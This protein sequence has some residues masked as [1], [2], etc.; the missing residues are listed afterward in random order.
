MAITTNSALIS[1]IR[2]K[3]G[4]LVFSRNASGPFVREYVS[5]VQPN[6]AGQQLYTSITADLT[7]YWRELPPRSKIRWKDFARDYPYYNAL[8]QQRF[9]TG[10]QLFCRQNHWIYRRT[11]T[12]IYDP[13][14]PRDFVPFSASVDWPSP[15]T[16]RM[17]LQNP[18]QLTNMFF[19][20][21]ATTQ[22]FAS[23]TKFFRPDYRYFAAVANTATGPFSIYT[24]YRN[25]FPVIITEDMRIG[26]WVRIFDQNTGWMSPGYYWDQI[27]TFA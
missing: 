7:E 20:L 25:V 11:D 24:V 16:M 19:L 26:F 18:G 6:S 8:G 9:Y 5:P 23:R 12:V 17:T 27:V 13:L 1:E 15:L 22:V 4:N 21:Y 2:G 3:V 14:P 10:Y